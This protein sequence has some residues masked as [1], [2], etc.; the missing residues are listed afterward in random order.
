MNTISQ[1]HL[2]ENSAKNSF[3]FKYKIWKENNGGCGVQRAYQPIATWGY[4]FDSDSNTLTLKIVCRNWGNSNTT[5]ILNYFKELGFLNNLGCG[6][7]IAVIFLE[8]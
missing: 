6:N 2:I 4:C 3:F 5:W 7:N 8:L 1:M